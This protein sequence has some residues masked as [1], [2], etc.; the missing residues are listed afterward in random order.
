[1]DLQAIQD[2]SSSKSQPSLL[3]SVSTKKKES[4]VG[5]SGKMGKIVQRNYILNDVG[6]L[7]KKLKHEGRKSEFEI[8]TEAVDGS[9]I[10]VPLK[11]SFFEFVKAHMVHDLEEKDDIKC[12]ENAEAD[13]KIVNS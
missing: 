9:N 8:G 6:A 3:P 11:A 5:V 10:I 2:A 1:M 12:V 7:K 13:C 4:A